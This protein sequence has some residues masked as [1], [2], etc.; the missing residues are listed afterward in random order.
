MSPWVEVRWRGNN[1]LYPVRF[2]NK[3]ILPQVTGIRRLSEGDLIDY[4]R[5]GREPGPDGG[6][7]DDIETGQLP[8]DDE[9]ID[10]RQ[11]LSYFIRRFVEAIPGLEGEIRSAMH[12]R[13]ALQA[14]LFGPTSAMALVDQALKSLQFEPSPG[15]PRKTPSAVGFQ[16]VEITSTLYRC[17]ESIMSNELREILNRA[18]AQSSKRL[19]DLMSSYPELKRGTFRQYLNKFAGVKP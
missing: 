14:V 12:S 8:P 4:F 5:Y 10:T 9:P 15:E 3:T 11:I 1:S 2:D 17:I 18:I 7:G 19:Q 13:P 6:G 16:L